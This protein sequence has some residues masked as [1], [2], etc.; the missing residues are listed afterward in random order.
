LEQ[1]WKGQEMPTTQPQ[2]C[3]LQASAWATVLDVLLQGLGQEPGCWDFL[4]P[5]FTILRHRALVLEGHS[6]DVGSPEAAGWV[7]V[8]ANSL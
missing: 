7:W 8:R 2:L 1:E 6:P 4:R 5:G 3:L